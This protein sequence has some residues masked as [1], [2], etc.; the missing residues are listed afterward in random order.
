MV[1]NKN[2]NHVKKQGKRGMND[3]R[4]RAGDITEWE[5]D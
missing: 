1:A 4:V 3:Q 2:I 5:K